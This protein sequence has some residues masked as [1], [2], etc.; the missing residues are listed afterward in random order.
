MLS[1]LQPTAKA[2]PCNLDAR[3]SANIHHAMQLRFALFGVK[4][5]VMLL[6][7]LPSSKNVESTSHR[8]RVMAL[9]IAFSAGSPAIAQEEACRANLNMLGQDLISM[10]RKIPAMPPIAQIYKPVRRL[11]EEAK[12]ARSRGD[13]ESCIT[14]TN[15]ALKYSKPYGRHY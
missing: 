5:M 6:R 10:L 4:L 7:Y 15:L 1:T 12:Y 2:T 11:Y 13:F 14:K 9:A 8:V 3:D